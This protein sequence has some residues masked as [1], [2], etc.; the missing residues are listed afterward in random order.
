V[1]PHSPVL[2][3]LYKDNILSELGTVVRLP[4]YQVEL[5]KEQ[6]EKIDVFL[7]TLQQNPYSPPGEVTVAPDLLNLLIGQEKV[8]R[9]ADGVVFSKAA[10]D[11]MVRKII[12][13]AKEQGSITLAEVRDMFTTSRKY[14]KALLEYM[15][16]KKLTKRVGDIRVVK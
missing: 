5:T 1:S 12:A 2:Q 9:V 14:A 6:Q 11:E 10:Y 7:R 13:H 15:D 3:K 16:E 8:V 4:T